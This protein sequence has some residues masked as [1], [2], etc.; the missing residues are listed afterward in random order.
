MQPDEHQ[1]R[2]LLFTIM[3]KHYNLGLTDFGHD[4][5]TGNPVRTLNE[6]LV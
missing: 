5:H 4:L 3:N 1:M 6:I 2:D